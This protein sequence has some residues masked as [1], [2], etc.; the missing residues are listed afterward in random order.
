MGLGYALDRLDRRVLTRYPWL[1]R[2]PKRPVRFKVLFVLALGVTQSLTRL[3]SG[4]TWADVGESLIFYLTGMALLSPLF[5]V[6][7][8]RR[9]KRR[10]R[11]RGRR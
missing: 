3:A 5:M 6:A 11:S 1:W 7:F 9:A 4:G 8:R 10:A 2:E